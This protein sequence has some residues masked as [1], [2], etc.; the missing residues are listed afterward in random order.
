[1]LHNIT[2][3]RACV[4]AFII[5]L[6]SALFVSVTTNRE[7]ALAVDDHSSNRGAK[8]FGVQETCTN[9]VSIKVWDPTTL[10]YVLKDPP[11]Y[12][13]DDELWI[14]YDVENFSCQDVSVSVALTGSV[15][16]SRIHDAADP[17]DACLTECTIDSASSVESGWYGGVVKWDLAAHP[18]GQYALRIVATT[19]DETLTDD[20]EIEI[21]VT[22]RD[23]VVDV[24]LSAV[25]PSQTTAIIGQTITFEVSVSNAGESSV[26]PTVG[27]FVDDTDSPVETV[28]SPAIAPGGVKELILPWDT[29]G[30]SAGNHS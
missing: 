21:P 6:T 10:N 29:S 28:Q 11:D 30:T 17:G 8:L 24:R 4:F 1:M 25:V 7:P 14:Y 22:L 27:L 13:P 19:P 12:G 2:A 23:P 18:A 3:A 16:K 26:E 20:N 5:L 15:S 9:D